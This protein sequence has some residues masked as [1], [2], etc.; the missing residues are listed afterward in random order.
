MA[1]KFTNT[2]S[3]IQ[4]DQVSTNTV[5]CDGLR[6][7]H[8]RFV[9]LALFN[10]VS[11][12]VKNRIELLQPG[13]AY[14]VKKICGGLFWEQLSSGDQK[15]AGLCVAELVERGELALSSAGRTPANSLQYSLR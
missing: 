1:K 9:Q 2:S 6:L 5:E 7:I 8:G 14:T 10:R 3:G 4:L 12:Q 11:R 13:V 15:L